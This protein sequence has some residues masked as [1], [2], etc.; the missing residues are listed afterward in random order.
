MVLARVLVILETR[1]PRHENT[2]QEVGKTRATPGQPRPTPTPTLLIST[3]L[4]PV[5]FKI[6]AQPT[7]MIRL[8]QLGDRPPCNMTGLQPRLIG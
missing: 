5:I 1:L 6:E 4:R 2:W 8:H 3:L 7:A